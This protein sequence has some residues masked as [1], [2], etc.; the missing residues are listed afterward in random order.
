MAIRFSYDG[1]PSRGFDTVAFYQ[2]YLRGFLAWH[3]GD[4]VWIKGGLVRREAYLI[5]NEKLKNTV[6]CMLS[7]PKSGASGYAIAVL[8]PEK[9]IQE[10]LAENR[11]CVGHLEYG[12]IWLDDEETL[13]PVEIKA[14]KPNPRC[15]CCH[16]T[17]QNRAQGWLARLE[18]LETELVVCETCLNDFP[19]WWRLTRRCLP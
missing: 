13:D 18:D 2:K 11:E 4:A 14:E 19:I 15:E 8:N 16:E 3:R 5:F 6:A 17:I 7:D 12:D 10:A 9:I 1:G